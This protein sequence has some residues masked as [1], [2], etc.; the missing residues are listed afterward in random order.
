MARLHRSL[1]ETGFAGDFLAWTP[2]RFPDGCPS[3]REV[4]FA[5]KPFCFVQA[6][7][8]HRLVLWMDSS[9]VAVRPLDSLFRCIAADG[10]LLFG[11]GRHKVGEWAGDL[12]L[13]YF[14]MGREEA[15]KADEVHAA[16]IGLD[17]GSPIANEFLDLW[18][19]AARDELAFRGV[20]EP[21]DTQDDYNAVKW[22]HDGRV[23]ADPR[24][25]GH[26]H[27]Q[28][29]AGIL[30]NRLGM[31]LR[32]SGLQAYP[33]EGVSEVQEETLIMIDRYEVNPCPAD[34]SPILGSEG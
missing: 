18:H 33:R 28:T 5:F 31:T 34:L 30:A 16:V 8:E 1:V 4:P 12:A 23:S 7:R 9:C 3:H 11:N 10:Y 27:D 26:R 13:E 2:G 21:L 6:R 19:A 17:L 25:R 14:G 20:K 29:V 22:N 15:M 32:R 24:V